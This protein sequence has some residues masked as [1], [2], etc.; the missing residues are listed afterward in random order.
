MITNHDFDS[1]NCFALI[2]IGE[3]RL[4]HTIEKPIN[5]ALRQRVVIH[6]NFEGLS[7]SEVSEYIYHKFSLA[8][9]STGILGE[10]TLPA[11]IS[12]CHGSPRLIDNLMTEALILGAQLK[13]TT[14]DT[15]VFM[16]SINNLTLA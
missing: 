8:G 7:E 2:L 3:P 16:A 10:G 4:N 14:L 12:H 9:A 11:I 15:E 5:D 6:Y 13:K 1:L